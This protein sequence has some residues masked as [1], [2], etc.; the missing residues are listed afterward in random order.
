MPSRLVRTPGPRK[1]EDVFDIEGRNVVVT[2]AASGLGRA[3]A[4]GL[5]ALGANV[6]A[7]DRNA[8]G[9][10]N[11]MTAEIGSRGSLMTFSCDLSQRLSVTKALEFV[12]DECR[13]LD[14]LLH[15]A[16]IAGP[17][18]RVTEVAD[19]DWENV[20][21]TNLG[22]AFLLTRAAIPLFREGQIGKIVLTSSTWG[23]VGSRRV[24][25][26]AYAA[27]KAGVLGL[28][29]QL[30]MEL[31][32]SINVNAIVPAGI[33]SAIADGFYEDPQAVKA[34]LSD[35]P[36]AEIRE[37]E[38]IVGLCLLLST[39]ASDHITGAVLPVDGGY[40]AY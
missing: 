36:T 34:L 23:I 21:Q 29:V 35:L 6:V 30:A 9:L 2:G 20:I 17:L 13:D 33:R 4:V 27:S 24:P 39:R 18:A 1:L 10:E 3:V 25:V 26:S 40:L 7:L 19:A 12:R 28:S 22:S 8:V 37:A 11:L 38:A 31:A 32:P 16:G 5:A 15:L 14:A